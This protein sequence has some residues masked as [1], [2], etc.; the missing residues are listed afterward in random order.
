[1]EYS[2]SES[3][4]RLCTNVCQRDGGTKVEVSHQLLTGTSL[5]P[6]ALANCHPVFLYFFKVCGRAR[7]QS[8]GSYCSKQ[9][10]FLPTN[11]HF[12]GTHGVSVLSA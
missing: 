6:L 10:Y 4:D 11:S 9:P 12:L 2:R 1:M 3:T 7:R 8:M 5:P